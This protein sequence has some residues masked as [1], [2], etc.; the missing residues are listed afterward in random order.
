MSEERTLPFTSTARPSDSPLVE[1]VWRARSDQAG[2]FTSQAASHWEL[3][4]T[5]LRGKTSVTVRGPETK[6]TLADCPPDAEF[7]GIV[8]K[9]GAFMPHLPVSQLLDRNDLTLPA[10][11]GRSFWLHGS[12]WE[13]P[14]FDNADTFVDR[15]ARAGLLVRDNLIEAVLQGQPTELSPRTVRR[16]FLRATG[17]TPGTIHQI[18][19]ARR[20][21]ALLR[22]G[23][24]I[25]DTVYEACYFDQPHLTR[26]LRHFFG[27]TPAQIL[28]ASR[29]EPIPAESFPL[30]Y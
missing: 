27:Q 7:L 5:Q 9:L 28:A 18:E 14:G 20:A 24:S 12:A 3:V 2:R 22:G 29:S 21:V 30:Q 25:L 6:A 8:F 26:S 16:R 13:L 23:M 15:L 17:L 10:A 4:V 11:A 1:M 19:R